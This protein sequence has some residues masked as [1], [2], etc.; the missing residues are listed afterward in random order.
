M[1]RAFTLAL[2]LL[3]TCVV[4]HAQAVIATSRATVDL[5]SGTW[6]ELARGKAVVASIER[7]GDL[8]AEVVTSAMIEGR[9][10]RAIVTVVST[11]SSP[12][13][14]VNWEQECLV[15][16]DTVWS[17]PLRGGH[18]EDVECT[19]AT[20]PADSA[21]MLKRRP[22]I[23]EAIA[24][25]SLEMPDEVVSMSARIFTRHGR[26]M[27]IDMWADKAFAGLGGSKLASLPALVAASHAAYA[28]ELGRCVRESLFSMR[29]RTELPPI[30]FST[31]MPPVVPLRVR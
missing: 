26:M 28:E 2:A 6:V 23:R 18:P 8:V 10:V 25:R 30:R 17:M 4:A 22:E 15:G 13:G 7:W 14:R 16:T 9:R 27:S 29:G 11:P 19:G 5:G 21:A 20:A 24:E 3:C 12:G 1:T 31:E